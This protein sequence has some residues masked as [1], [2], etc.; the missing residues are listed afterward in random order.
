MRLRW[1]HTSPG[2]GRKMGSERLS[3]RREGAKYNRLGP[4]RAPARPAQSTYCVPGPTGGRDG[5]ASLAS[6]PGNGVQPWPWE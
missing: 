3:Q 1:T 2:E 5:H 6:A 4:P